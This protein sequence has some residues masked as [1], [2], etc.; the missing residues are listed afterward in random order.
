MQAPDE[1]LKTL[2]I[3]LGV[4]AATTVLFRRLGQPV[5]L[6]YLLAGLIIG[7]HV[8]IPLVADEGIVR[9]LSELGVIL[10]MFSLGLDFSIRKL[11]RV[12][13]TAGLIAVIECSL[14]L[15]LGFLTGRR[16][17][18]TTLESL[19]AGA[20]VAIS[21]TTVVAKIFDERNV[22]GRLRDLVVGILIVED[23]IAV[24]L[25]TV[26]TVLASGERVSAGTLASTG[27]RLAGFL[28]L[29][30]S[31]GLLVIPR[32]V[33]GI[34][35]LG[36]PETTLVAM[37]GLCFSL[38]LLAG[39]AGY[40]LALGAFLAGALVAESGQGEA[41]EHLVRPVR[42]MF[43]AIFFVSVGMLIVPSLVLEHWKAA[44][45]L[46]G[47]VLL[48]KVAGVA[49]GAFLTGHGTRLSVQAG[50]S[51]AQI[52]EFSFIL[53]A[54]GL[55]LGA[56][57]EFLYPV[58]VAVSAATTLSTPWMIRASGRA[59]NWMDRKLP[60]P[61]QTLASLYANWLEH[62][63][64]AFALQPSRGSQVRRIVLLLLLD[65]ALL[66]ALLI[67]TSLAL[68]PLT[69]FVHVS[70]GLRDPLAR[71][72]PGALG[73]AACI[74]FVLGI[75]RL[76]RRLGNLLAEMALPSAGE[77][78]KVDLSAAPRRTLVVTLQLGILILLGAPMAA[79]TQPFLPEFQG[80]A[81]LLILAVL[82]VAFWR[83]AADLQGHVQ[84]GA[85]IIVQALASQLHRAPDSQAKAPVPHEIHQLLPGLGDPVPVRLPPPCYAVGKTLA[86]LN[87]R[88]VTG[89]TVLALVRQG[90]NVLTPDPR[91][92]FREEDVLVL[93]G[94]L[95]AIDSAKTL[96]L[97]GP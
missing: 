56:T 75:L 18:W 16:L 95:E 22:Q 31:L 73:A 84:A 67:G 34:L 29:L 59:A 89:A 69:R 63:R 32:M 15:W 97:R 96:L 8:P 94:S 7:P 30:V 53:A 87:L 72:L 54:M 44:A 50:M 91:E 51:M 68:D 77:A 35:R 42:D 74:P 43:A 62:I 57:R 10:L 2:A 85:G 9:T 65:A 66:I 47:V 21:S 48:G 19:F 3:V 58:V 25:M 82:G 71:L 92:P 49:T 38:A 41:V 64:S 37:I 23:L 46:T 24:L 60:R 1:F 14:L 26:L 70:T 61:I 83:S 55:A 36:R 79:V 12:G 88:G 52:G 86:A 45:A 33:R 81:L 76:A 6:G 20:V 40:S 11:V 80:L 28:V 17:G 90:Q 4:A 5:V 27:G 93:A 13:P 78:G 39:W